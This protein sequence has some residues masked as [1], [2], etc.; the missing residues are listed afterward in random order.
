MELQK[1]PKHSQRKLLFSALVPG[2]CATW[3]I[4]LPFGKYFMGRE[5]TP[6]G[7]CLSWDPGL[8]WLH[9]ISDALIFLS[10]LSIP[11]T[12]IYFVR[13]RRDLPFNWMFVCF[14]VFIVACGFTHALEIWTLWH[15]DYWLSGVVKAITAAASVPTAVLLVRLVPKALAIPTAGELNA[16]EEALRVSEEK[17]RTL[18]DAANDAIITADVTGTI[19]DFNRAAEKMFA[20]SKAETI[21]QPL[22]VL[23]PRRFHDA[24]LRGLE[25]CQQG[26]AA[27][28]LG[29]TLELQGRRC[30]GTE[31]P[32]QLSLA[33]WT[34]KNQRFFTGVLRDITERVRV[35]NEIREVNRQMEGRNAELAAVNQELESFSYCVSHDLRA[36][37]RAID[38]FS[39][40]L[41]QDAEKKLVPEEKQ[42]LDRIRTATA[43]MTRLIDDMLNLARTARHEMVQQTVDLSRLAQEVV[44]Q[45][46]AAD[47]GRSASVVVAPGLVA[48]G[49][50]QLLRVLLENLI[51]NSWK[52]TSKRTDARIEVGVSE[53]GHERVFVVRDNGPG[54]DMKYADRL[55]GV[56]QRLHRGTEFPGTGIGLASVQRIVHRHGGRIWAEAVPGEGA[57]FYFVLNAANAE[58]QSARAA[59][60]AAGAS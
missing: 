19:V 25:R 18:V 30:D 37:L 31:F 1:H 52:F 33:S 46:R 4:T 39:L 40:A 51:G 34:A 9:V 36:P 10:Y 27:D 23:M 54:F 22:T 16:A 20:R 15:A 42:H 48:E 5:F 6:H 13:R 38:G 57:S 35:E 47:P 50:P 60:R 3:A 28:A 14:G 29:K 44:I 55:F 59:A 49:D 7:Y 8:V 2:P 12:L 26:G 41:L 43:R 58:P 24:Y 53:H 21:G 17:F 11:F 45:L 32:L 56:F